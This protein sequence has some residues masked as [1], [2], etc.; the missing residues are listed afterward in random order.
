MLLQRRRVDVFTMLKDCLIHAVRVTLDDG[1]RLHK[2]AV[3]GGRRWEEFWRGS[4]CEWMLC[5]DGEGT[6][7][8]ENGKVDVE[9]KSGQCEGASTGYLPR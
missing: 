2:M 1:W 6:G 3:N 5:R 7:L 8:R 4:V 9:K